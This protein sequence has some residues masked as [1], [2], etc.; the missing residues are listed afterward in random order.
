MIT[1]GKGQLGSDC[2]EVLGRS[3]E[4]TALGS[5]DLDITRLLDV[6]AV[7]SRFSPEVILN[8]AAYTRVDACE[9]E[10]DLAW[11]VNAKGPKNLALSVEK[12][13][14]RLIHIST[15]Y[16][17]DGR[18]KVPEPYLEEDG[19][20]PMSHYG[21]S[22]LEGEKAVRE[23]TERHVILRTAWLYG[24][25]GHN[26]LKTMLTLA[27]RDSP[28]PIKVVND[29]FGSPTWSHRLAIQLSGLIDGGARGTF[30]AT[31]E[32]YCSW[33][34]LALYFL[35]KMG[36]AHSLV[37]CTSD[38]YPTPAARPKNS[39]LEN[40][41]L[42]TEGIHLMTDWKADVAQFVRRFRQRLFEEHTDREEKVP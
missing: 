21:K 4:V 37:P 9:T 7:V 16:V 30:H 22:K 35:E 8:C 26:F 13:G 1:G 17:F 34:E 25:N 36:V 2:A 27:L 19:T 42:K 11:E 3:H 40:R 32:G 23:T 29:Q 10:K 39:I 33:Y 41:R 24:I 14:G 31:A 38:E 18:K 15:D 20:H 5:A 12:Y 6:D 28:D